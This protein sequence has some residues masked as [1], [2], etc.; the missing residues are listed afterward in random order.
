MCEDQGEMSKGGRISSASNI[1]ESA[2]PGASEQFSGLP[3]VGRGS[4]ISF[5]INGT[6]L[7]SLDSGSCILLDDSS[8]AKGFSS[9]ICNVLLVLANPISNEPAGNR[10]IV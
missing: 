7:T 1:S 9:T 3:V 2:L 6:S 4:F 10:A 8:R 5:F